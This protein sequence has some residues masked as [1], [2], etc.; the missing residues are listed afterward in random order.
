MEGEVK[1]SEYRNTP[2]WD[3]W[4][5]MKTRCN[6]PKDQAYKRYGGR[7]I[8]VCER[9]DTFDKFLEDMGPR[10]TLEHSLDR[11]DNSKGYCKDNC[12]WSTKREQS[13]NRSDNHLITVNG[14]T[15][16][17]TEWSRRI[18]VPKQTIL[19]RIRMGW[20]HEDAI[21]RPVA[22]HRPKHI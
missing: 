8:T 19:S 13:N 18:E 5:M 17:I 9:W 2:E 16:T 15:L 6:N 21:T 20:S 22:I 10:P 11:K 4:R 7:G 1:P 3:S 14:L 12:R